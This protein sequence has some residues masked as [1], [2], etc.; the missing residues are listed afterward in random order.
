VSFAAATLLGLFAVNNLITSHQPH[1]NMQTFG[2]I[3]FTFGLI[4]LGMVNQLAKDVK[5][6][7]RQ[8]EDLK[9]RLP[10][11]QDF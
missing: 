2:I 3:G 11:L 5:K 4:A 8:M 1:S 9:K 6:L 10:P 7:Q